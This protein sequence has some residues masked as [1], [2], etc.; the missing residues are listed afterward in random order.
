M[1]TGQQIK[2]LFGISKFKYAYIQ[3]ILNLPIVVYLITINSRYPSHPFPYSKMRLS[4]FNQTKIGKSSNGIVRVKWTKK[5]QPILLDEWDK[6]FSSNTLFIL[7]D[8]AGGTIKSSVKNFDPG[9][10]N[11]VTI[12]DLPE[13]NEIL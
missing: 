10:I 4:R 9:V 12:D 13:N 6:S 1:T 5:T 2:R 7:Q 11:A 3:Q 8:I